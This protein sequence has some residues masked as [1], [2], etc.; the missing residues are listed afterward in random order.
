MLGKKNSKQNI[1]LKRQH[2]DEKNVKKEK[3][4]EVF[5]RQLKP[6]L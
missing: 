3:Y 2:T 6:D 4:I 5:K 1:K